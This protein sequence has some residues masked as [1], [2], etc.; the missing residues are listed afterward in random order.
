MKTA[1]RTVALAGAAMLASG[2]ATLGQLGIQAPNFSV[3]QQQHAQLR[4]LP[5]S[6]NHPMGG[7]AV[8]LFARVENPNPVGITLSR[9]VG[10]LALQGRSAAAVDF[11]LGVPLQA[12]GNVVVPMDLVL[13]FSDVPA[14]ADVLMRAVTGQSVTYALD[15]TVGVD[16]GLLGEPSFGPM[17]LLQ[18]EL[19]VTR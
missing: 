12:G 13:D 14:L 17:A 15:G 1:M 3:D 19:R 2:C 7:A 11:P 16:A 10:T 6:V 18:G 8:R 9:V 4:L 5:P